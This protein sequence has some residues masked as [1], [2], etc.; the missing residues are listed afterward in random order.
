VY[1]VGLKKILQ[2][3]VTLGSREI[4]RRLCGHVEKRVTRRTA[5][6]I[7]N[8]RDQRR[9]QVKGLMDVGE[10]VQ[11][12]DHPVIVLQGMQTHPR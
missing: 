6:I 8:L 7:L 11:Q 3:K 12:L 9:N 1:W 5:D 10:L 2:G 4:F